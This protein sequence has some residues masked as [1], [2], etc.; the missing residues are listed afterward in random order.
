MSTSGEFD[1][2][3]PFIAVHSMGGPFDDE[4][5]TA[6]YQMGLMDEALRHGDFW[7]RPILTE[8]RE[9]AD[10][11]AMSHGALM[12]VSEDQPVDGWLWVE[13]AGGE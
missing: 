13:F 3:M 6:G 4:S 11:V 1:L 8:L 2:V 10:L 7:G 9:Q 12:A 5:F